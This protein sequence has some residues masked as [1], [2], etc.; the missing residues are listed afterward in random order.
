M[1]P[2]PA[3]TMSVPRQAK[4]LICMMGTVKPNAKAGPK[5]SAI[6][7]TP[8]KRARSSA[9]SA[10]IAAG[11]NTV[12]VAIEKPKM[13]VPANKGIDPGTDRSS[14]PAVIPTSAKPSTRSRPNR[15]AS[16]GDIGATS[17][18]IANGTLVNNDSSVSPYP[19]LERIS[20]SNGPNDVVGIRR[21]RAPSSMAVSP[22]RAERGMRVI[23]VIVSDRRAAALDAW[24]QSAQK[25]RVVVPRA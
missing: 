12:A 13:S 20:G 1:I 10:L 25:A 4:P 6:E 8:V 11:S 18:V 5:L 2:Q 14:V 17:K 3:Q 24:E 22:I 19:V 16:H 15:D 21:L 9:D 23:R 7:Y